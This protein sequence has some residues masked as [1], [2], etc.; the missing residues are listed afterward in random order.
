[1]PQ[2]GLDIGGNQCFASVEIS[3]CHVSRAVRGAREA[4]NPEPAGLVGKGE[5]RIG[6]AVL[7]REGL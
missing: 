1:M 7:P 2:V 6:E 4:R 3:I 5:S